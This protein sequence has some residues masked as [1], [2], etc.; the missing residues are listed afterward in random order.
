MN[1]HR[2]IWYQGKVRLEH[3]V[4][5]EQNFGPIPAGLLVHHI[6]GDPLD[7]R[8]ENLALVSRR[9]HYYIHP[10]PRLGTGVGHMEG[11]YYVR[12]GV[13]V[14]CGGPTKRHTSKRCRS[15][16]KKFSWQEGVYGYS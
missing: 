6:N 16:S 15:C 10:H 3:R 12:P 9:R 2:Y 11:S 4:V 13:C 14:D 1:T 8:P 7:N 5:W